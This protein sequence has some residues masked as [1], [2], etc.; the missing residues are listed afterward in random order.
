MYY[1]KSFDDEK[2]AYKVHQQPNN[3]IDS[4]II[5]HGF[6]GDLA[7]LE[8]LVEVLKKK[9][10]KKEIISLVLRGHS[11]S[12]KT[13]PQNENYLEVVHAKDLHELIKHLKIN[14]PIII[15]HSL[16]GILIQSYINQDLLPKPKKVFFVCSTTQMVGINILRKVFYKILTKTPNNNINFKTKDR[17]FYNQFKKGWDINIKRY[18]HDTTVIGN[19]FL[20]FIHFLSINGWKNNNIKQLDNKDYYYIFG[21]NDIIVPSFKQYKNIKSLNKLNKIEINSGHISPLTHPKQLAEL[22]NK[23]L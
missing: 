13:F 22:I 19:I 5:V 14:N 9:N 7:F 21:K 12:S 17:L 20:W 3:P 2:I 15:G 1:F 23:Y 4:I 18:L 16:G 11:F 10:E 6:G 8:D